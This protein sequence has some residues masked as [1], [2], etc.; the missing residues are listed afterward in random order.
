VKDYFAMKTND[1]LELHG[2]H[3]PLSGLS[4]EAAAQ[5]FAEEGPN[6]LPSAKSEDLSIL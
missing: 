4:E 5:K 2:T 6:E 3:I 1:T